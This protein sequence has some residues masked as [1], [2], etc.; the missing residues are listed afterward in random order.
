MTR[1]LAGF[2]SSLAEIFAVHRFAAAVHRKAVS[3]PFASR[4]RS[5][6]QSPGSKK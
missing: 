3:P 5:S 2:F 6:N 1:R 4:Y